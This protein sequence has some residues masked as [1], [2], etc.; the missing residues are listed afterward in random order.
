M[1]PVSEKKHSGG[2]SRFRLPPYILPTIQNLYSFQFQYIRWMMN[3]LCFE[4]IDSRE[5]P[6]QNVGWKYKAGV[7]ANNGGP[8]A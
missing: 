3:N 8:G 5:S 4:A 6:G 2:V 1:P 7:Q